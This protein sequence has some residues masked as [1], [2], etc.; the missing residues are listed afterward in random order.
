M[1]LSS[2]NQVLFGNYIPN[3][4]KYAV[5]KIGYF[6]AINSG[7]IIS[8]YGRNDYGQ[9]KIGDYITGVKQIAAGAYHT[10]LLFENGRVSGFGRNDYGQATLGN[11]LTNVVKIAAGTYHTLALLSNGRVTGWGQETVTKAKNDTNF[12]FNYD[13]ATDNI[14]KAGYTNN[15]VNV[16]DIAAGDQSSYAVLSNNNITGWGVAKWI[17]NDRFNL[18]EYPLNFGPI[19]KIT[20][21]NNFSTFL[22][23][24]TNKKAV[25]IRHY[26]TAYNAS[27]SPIPGVSEI[28]S[29]SYDPSFRGPAYEWSGYVLNSLKDSTPTLDDHL[30][31]I[32]D[33]SAGIDY[34]MAI[35]GTGLITGWGYPAYNQIN[36][37][38]KINLSKP[39]TP[40]TGT[41]SFPSGPGPIGGGVCYNPSLVK[42][43]QRL[44]P[45]NTGF[46]KINSIEAGWNITAAL[47][48]GS[49]LT[50]IGDQNAFLY[51]SDFG[52]GSEFLDP[53]YNQ[54][55]YIN[56]IPTGDINQN[57]YINKYNVELVRYTGHPSGI[58]KDWP[59]GTPSEPV[60]GTIYGQPF[61]EYL[62]IENK[63]TFPKACYFIDGITGVA[64]NLDS[65]WIT[66][67]PKTGNL[68]VSELTRNESR[69]VFGFI[70][71]GA[72]PASGVNNNYFYYMAGN[73]N[74]Q[75]T[76]N[77]TS[78]YH[79]I[80]CT[81][82]N[83][84]NSIS[85]TGNPGIIFSKY[86]SDSEYQNYNNANNLPQP[87]EQKEIFGSQEYETN[88]VLLVIG[89]SKKSCG[90]SIYRKTTELGSYAFFSGVTNG[91]SP[92]GFCLDG[93]I[94]EIIDYSPAF[95]NPPFGTIMR[96]QVIPHNDLGNGDPL[97]LEAKLVELD[98]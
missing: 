47:N 24:D 75:I 80:P 66:R 88:K 60:T 14:S 48:S 42:T 68:D 87:I 8:G 97:F 44:F 86:L 78:L 10:V 22:L 71:T 32:N 5:G 79:E 67:L 83:L 58:L 35:V 94:H 73:P 91:T 76:S 56:Q 85:Y 19:R 82:W 6:V 38:N 9:Y 12:P 62:Y 50:I 26:A 15:L 90:Y 27:A 89:G 31:G 64:Y 16:I 46:F 17:Y 74:I 61:F 65:N 55:I 59:Y 21:S 30:T 36:F 43:V 49:G 18:I 41:I 45:E 39:K 11:D 63:N 69:G 28:F 72:S 20:A 95:G 52:V 96:Y 34:T 23:N 51:E 1:S 98:C 92:Q 37:Y 4:K 53:F 29:S 93:K 54:K 2:G 33:I 40:F 70:Y 13:R 77:A 25:S 57:L 7:D 81:Q 3:I 84:A